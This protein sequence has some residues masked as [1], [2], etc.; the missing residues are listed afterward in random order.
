MALAFPPDSCL[1]MHWQQDWFQLEY[2][3]H[4]AEALCGLGVFPQGQEGHFPPGQLTPQVPAKLLTAKRAI[5]R[6]MMT[7]FIMKINEIFYR[8]MYQNAFICA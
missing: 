3:E 4:Q 5:M 7:D 6:A 2:L 1:I 8:L